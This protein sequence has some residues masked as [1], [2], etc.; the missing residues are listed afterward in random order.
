KNG[1]LTFDKDKIITIYELLDLVFKM[2][3]IMLKYNVVIEYGKF[4]GLELRIVSTTSGIRIKAD[5]IFLEELVINDSNKES[6]N[7]VVY[8]PKTDNL[9]FKHDVTY[10]MLTD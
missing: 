9:F 4:T 2:Y 10:Y 3:G 6:I 8:K 5:N 1:T 7:K